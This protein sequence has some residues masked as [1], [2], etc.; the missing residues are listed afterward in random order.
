MATVLGRQRMLCAA[1]LL[2]L[3]L[4]PL[5]V[6]D[7]AGAAETPRRGGVLRAVIG[8]APPSRDPHPASTCATRSISSTVL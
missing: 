1:V 7:P 8:A 6:A 5:S 3:L 4:V 2:A